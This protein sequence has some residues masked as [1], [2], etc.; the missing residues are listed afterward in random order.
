MVS[1]KPHLLVKI[2]YSPEGRHHDPEELAHQI[3]TLPEVEDVYAIAHH[4][5]NGIIQIGME[6]R[7]AGE[8]WDLVVVGREEEFNENDNLS[9]KLW[10]YF[11]HAFAW[12]HGFEASPVK[13]SY[14]TLRMELYIAQKG[15]AKTYARILDY[16]WVVSVGERKHFKEFVYYYGFDP[17]EGPPKHPAEKWFDFE[18]QIQAPTS[19]QAKSTAF[20]IRNYF[21]Q[22]DD[23]SLGNSQISS[24]GTH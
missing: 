23:I 13:Q 14:V 20:R 12:I 7:A 5:F 24:R 16:K 6:I 1:T 3:K 10:K 15:L 18:I 4:T 19:K 8:S 22:R 2:A 9:I 11:P 17:E 21:R